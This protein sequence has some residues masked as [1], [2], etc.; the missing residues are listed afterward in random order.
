MA[1][2]KFAAYVCSGCGLGEQLDIKT[3][4]KIALKEGKMKV[5]KNHPFL[6]SAAGVQM[7]NDDIAN[8]AV[9]HICI[10]ACSRRSKT[11]A[12]HF[13]TVAMS[14]ANLRE[15]VLWV[16]RKARRTTKCAR[17]WPTTTCAWAAPN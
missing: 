12:F 13:P 5:V 10:A 17:K 6:C 16:S 14:R 11:E 2:N 1:D 4:E 8:E 15:G 3:L 9:T 7:I